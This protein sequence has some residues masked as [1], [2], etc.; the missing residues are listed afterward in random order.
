[1]LS[2]TFTLQSTQ[3]ILSMKRYHSTAHN[4]RGV[5]TVYT[6]IIYYNDVSLSYIA[7][8]PL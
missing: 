7:N 4:K 1:M 2:K 6:E 8:I 3:L 5:L